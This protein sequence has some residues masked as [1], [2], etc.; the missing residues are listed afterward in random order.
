MTTVS[1]L[2]TIKA[3]RYQLVHAPGLVR[4][5][6]K[7]SREIAK[8]PELLEDVTSHLR[9]Y[10]DALAYPPNRVF[11]GGMLPDGLLEIERP[12][13]QTTLRTSPHTRQRAGTAAED[14]VLSGESPRW[15]PFGETMPEE[16]LY[17]LLKVADAFDLVALEDGFAAQCR[18]SLSGHKLVRKD[19][20]QVLSGGRPYSAI[21]RQA[22][23]AEVSLPLFLRDG[24][25]VGCI[26]RAHEEDASL[27]ADVVLENLACKVTA[28][29]ALRTLLEDC[30]IDP[31]EIDYVL[32]TGEEAVGERYQRGGGNLAKAVAEM[33]GLANASGSDVKAFCCGPVHAL[34]RS[35]GRW[36]VPVCTARSLLSAGVPWPSWG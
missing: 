12:W 7:P 30:R 35:P 2:P 25:L 34:V 24:T 9:C 36:S 21:E 28:A 29:M 6:S 15:Q 32:N 5:G 17:G 19:E 31:S 27:T 8:R 4:H 11:L 23:D 10:E 14:T 20:L 13:F 16:E 3:V 33:C 1:T 18:E 26:S 22:A